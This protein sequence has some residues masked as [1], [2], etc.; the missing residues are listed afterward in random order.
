MNNHSPAFLR[1]RQDESLEPLEEGRN[2]ERSISTEELLDIF[3]INPL[4]L[5][6]DC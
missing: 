1:K 4:S 6:S 2:S 3:E 5:I